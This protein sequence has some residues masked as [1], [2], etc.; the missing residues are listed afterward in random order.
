MLTIFLHKVVL[1]AVIWV[2]WTEIK[3]TQADP[4]PSE[5]KTLTGKWDRFKLLP[6]LMLNLIFLFLLHLNK[7]HKK[8]K[9]S[10]RSIHLFLNNQQLQQK[11]RE[12]HLDLG[13]GLPESKLEG[14]GL[15]L[16]ISISGKKIKKCKYC[17]GRWVGQEWR[18]NPFWNISLLDGGWRCLQLLFNH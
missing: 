17:S 12:I 8:S 2:L 10:V 18:V 5:G 14:L 9:S 3:L 13:S 1:W 11:H 16:S 7:V 4:L 6:V 15:N